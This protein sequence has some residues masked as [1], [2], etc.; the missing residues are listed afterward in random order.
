MSSVCGETP[1]VSDSGIVFKVEC[2]LFQGSCITYFSVRF[3]TTELG[4]ESK[5]PSEVWL[6]RDEGENPARKPRQQTEIHGADNHNSNWF[7]LYFSNFTAG[8]VCSFPHLAK[9]IPQQFS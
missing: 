2:G 7:F 6:S 3:A 5:L 8:I 1:Q 4:A 9:R